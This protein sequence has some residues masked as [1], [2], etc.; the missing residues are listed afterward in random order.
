MRCTVL[1]DRFRLAFTAIATAALLS[2]LATAARADDLPTI[3]VGWVVPVANL[4]SI[5][6]EKPGIARHLGKTYQYQ[7]IRFASTVAMVTAMA[8]GDLDIGT[9]GYSAFAIAVANAGMSDLR[10]IGDEFRD[11]VPGYYS[12]EYMVRK[13]DSIK[14]VEDLKGKVIGANAVGGAMDIAM[15]VMF[16]KHGLDLKNDVTIVEG[17]LPNMKAMLSEQKVSLA[18]ATLPFSY[19]PEYRAI[20]R[21]LFTQRDAVGTTDMIV[22]AAR[23]PFLSKNRAAMVDFMEDAIRAAH[24]Y[25]DPANHR[26]VV[27]I[28][29]KFSKQPASNFADWLFT[30]KDFYRDP[31]L[32][33]DLAVLQKSIDLQAELGFV[34]TSFKIGDYTDLSIVK[35]AAARVK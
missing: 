19:D 23:T 12:D 4:P 11:G 20:A 27:D 8:T 32:L 1:L 17:G 34:K 24:F 26:E 29:A 5:L 15:R 33:P 35:E 25:L 3:R 16:R 9:L 28:A 30:K 14:R 13:D 6:F 18:E 10:V 22:W 7:P 2:A 31:N 21:P